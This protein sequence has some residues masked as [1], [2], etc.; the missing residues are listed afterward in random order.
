MVVG[1]VHRKDCE[2]HWPHLQGCHAGYRLIVVVAGIHN[3]L[4]NQTQLRI[5]E[6]FVGRDS[7]RLLSRMMKNLS[8]LGI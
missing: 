2:L 7:A 8:A 3:N 5:D 1:H 6:G 4:R